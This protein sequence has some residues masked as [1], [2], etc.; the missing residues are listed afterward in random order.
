[1]KYI[2]TTF[3]III[4]SMYIISMFN[5]DITKNITYSKSNGE[6]F[7]IEHYLSSKEDGMYM[8]IKNNPYLF[9]FAIKKGYIN[10]IDI[11]L[12]NESNFNYKYMDYSYYFE[13]IKSND[14]ETFFKLQKYLDVN[15][16]YI[17]YLKQ[18]FY[19]KIIY[20]KFNYELNNEFIRYIL[21]YDDYLNVEDYNYIFEMLLLQ[22]NLIILNEFK[23]KLINNCTYISTISTSIL[24]QTYPKLF[25][26]I[27]KH[28]LIDNH[29]TFDYSNKDILLKLITL[30]NY[31]LIE[32][33]LK[34][35]ND[36]Q[37]RLYL[38][39]YLKYNKDE[40]LLKLLKSLKMV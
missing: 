39:N 28:N 31:N 27:L 26:E 38:I 14:F 13:A 8:A 3:I 9:T 15:D 16:T 20:S 10:F 21:Q 6:N 29:I 33:F 25:E 12:K 17:N 5:K 34:N 11:V 35:K 23:Q 4:S 37:L 36:K 22:N 40:Q 19:Q 2:I 30:K 24:I 32:L 7:L 18:D 1:M